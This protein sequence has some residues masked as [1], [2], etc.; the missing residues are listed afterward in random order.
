MFRIVC[1]PT[2]GSIK[3]YLTDISSGSLMFVVCLVVFGSVIFEPVVRTVRRAAARHTVRTGEIRTRR[4]LLPKC[5]NA[6][7]V[8]IQTLLKGYTKFPNAWQSPQN[9]RRRNYDMK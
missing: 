9:S 1:D 7:L 3:Q 2:S 5:I 6:A 4:M 8:S